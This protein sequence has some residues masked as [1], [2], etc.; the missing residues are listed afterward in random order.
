MKNDRKRLSNSFD[1]FIFDW[2]GTL[3]SLRIIT[4]INESVKRALGLWNKDS[5]IK[6]FKSMDYNLKRRIE[7]G[8]ARRNDA[9]SLL[10]DIFLVLSK[11]RLHKDSIALLK[12]LKRKGKKIAILSNERGHKLLGELAYLKM[13]GYFDIVVSARDIKSMKPNATG[14]KAILH[15]LRAKPESAIYIGDMVDDVLTAKFAKIHS[16]AIADGFDS[17]H[18]LKSTKPDY[19]FSSIEALKDAL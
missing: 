19:I 10:S 14:I 7:A 13:L 11:P 4:R 8:D 12:A 3:N 1:T 16:C 15:F 9:I 2:D 18:T 5:A 6:D 17:Y